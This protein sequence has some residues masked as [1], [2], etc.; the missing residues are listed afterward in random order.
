LDEISAIVAGGRNQFTNRLMVRDLNKAY[1]AFCEP[2]KDGPLPDVATGNWGC[3]AFGG[4]KSLKVVQQILAASEAGRP[5]QYFTFGEKFSNKSLKQSIDELA[6]V[7]RARNLT[8]GDVFKVILAAAGKSKPDLFH[9][10]Q[11]LY[12][13]LAAGEQPNSA[14]AEVQSPAGS[15]SG[16]AN[17][18][19]DT[20]EDEEANNKEKPE[21]S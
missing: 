12:P 3:G 11:R 6:D 2:G 19:M 17:A 4:D 18:G 8:V 7:V 9:V 20:E 15:S 14:S 5:L 1:N 21:M 13:P 16:P 10:F